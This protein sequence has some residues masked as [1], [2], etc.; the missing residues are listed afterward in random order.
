MGII[1]INYLVAAT[2]GLLSSNTD[3]AGTQLLSSGWLPIA[4]IIGF[5][6]VV[7][8]FLIG[9]S[10]AKAGMSLTTIATRMSMIFP[11]FF[12]LFLF[13]EQISLLKLGKIAFTLVA[14]ALAIYQPP[15]KNIKTLYT[16]LPLILFI[17]SGSVDTL[18]KT[19][20]HRFVPD[21][22][23]QL[24]SSVLFGTSLL[25]SLLFIPFTREKLNIFSF[26]SLPLGIALGLANFGSLFFLM[27]ALNNSG[28]DSSLVFGINN[29]AI[30]CFSLLLGFFL[31][32][33]QL[34]KLNRIGVVLSLI[35]IILLTQL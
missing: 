11:I 3:L 24:F 30:V 7:M 15:R 34:S 8:F 10:T 31:F 1:I 6:F 22:Q 2:L 5:L 26:R 23:I 27:K 12:S 16:F 28:L 4:G 9:H 19:A 14:V 20:Q 29:L 13:D 33:E 25:A 35:G 32:K 21:H 18:V 17:G